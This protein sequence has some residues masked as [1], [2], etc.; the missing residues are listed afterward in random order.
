MTVAF[1][2][3]SA[4]AY[5]A[6]IGRWSRA[7]PRCTFTAGDALALSLPAQAFDLVVSHLVLNFIDDLGGA[8]R[9]MYRVSRVGARV[10][11]A[12]WD[13]EDGFPA[14]QMLW[15]EAAAAA[16]AMQAVYERWRVQPLARPGALLELW[17]GARLTDLREG[18]IEVVMH[19]R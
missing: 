8:A 19:I 4:V 7:H 2:S 10:A 9:E 5:E 11:A 15:R 6:A 1:D 17:R 3:A 16:P 13:I 12:V 18:S 14:M